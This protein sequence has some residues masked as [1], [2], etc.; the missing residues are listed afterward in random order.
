M[1][2]PGAAAAQHLEE[3]AGLAG[4]TPLPQL[5]AWEFEWPEAEPPETASYEAV[6]YRMS[7]RQA[8]EL[9]LANEEVEARRA[10]SSE[11]QSRV[12]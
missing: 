8:V 3:V 2:L 12:S 1:H 11:L 6:H 10:E 9:A 4:D 7:L 5:T